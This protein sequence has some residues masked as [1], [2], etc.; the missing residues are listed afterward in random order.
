VASL[1]GTKNGADLDSK[2]LG[3]TQKVPAHPSNPEG[4]ILPAA[5]VQVGNLFISADIKGTNNDPPPSRSKHTPIDAVLFLLC[6]KT[7]GLEE[8]EFAAKQANSFEAIAMHEWD[9]IRIVDI[10]H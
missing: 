5:L 10:G 3:V 4:G 6:G 1:R 7:T 9:L 8:Q 2:F